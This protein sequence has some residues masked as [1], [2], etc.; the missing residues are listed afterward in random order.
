MR[1]TQSLSKRIDHLSLLF[2]NYGKTCASHQ[3]LIVVSSVVV[4]VLMFWPAITT[5]WFDT[6]S[7]AAYLWPFPTWQVTGRPSDT[8]L[9]NYSKLLRV[10]QLVL[11]V[12]EDM[13]P[14]EIMLETWQIYDALSHIRIYDEDDE[15]SL[16][17]ICY[18]TPSQQCLVLSPLAYWN[19]DPD[20]IQSDTNV[21][22]TLSSA[23]EN[24]QDEKS[25]M[26]CFPLWYVLGGISEGATKIPPRIEDVR[27]SFFLNGTYPQVDEIWND[28][29]E[30]VGE[31]NMSI[32]LPERI[33]EED[34][35]SYF[36]FTKIKLP[37]RMSFDFAVLIF[38]YGAVFSYT[39]RALGARAHLVK[40]KL[41]LGCMAVAV[42]FAAS[43][44]AISIC[45]MVGIRLIYVPWECFL[46]FTIVVGVE[47]MFILT[48]AIVATSV[49]LPVKERVGL[50]VK[51][52]G[53]PI[54]TTLIFELIVLMLGAMIGLPS[55]REF[56][57]LAS[58]ALVTDFALQMTFFLT[59]LSVDIRRLELS[60]LHDRRVAKNIQEA[61]TK[62]AEDEQTERNGGSAEMEKRRASAAEQERLIGFRNVWM[63]RMVS[64][65]VI[66]SLIIFVA[67]IHSM[68]NGEPSSSI[69]RWIQS[70]KL[71]INIPPRNREKI[72][73][74]FWQHMGLHHSDEL[75][76][77]AVP[78]P[79][80]VSLHD[81]GIESREIELA[82]TSYAWLARVW[83]IYGPVMIAG[84]VVTFVLYRIFLMRNKTKP[85]KQNGKAGEPRKRSNKWF[86]WP[87]SGTLEPDTFHPSVRVITLKG[88]HFA[89]VECL[90]ASSDAAAIV[91]C[92]LD[93]QIVAWDSL[94]GKWMRRL[95]RMVEMGCPRGCGRANW[96]GCANE[97]VSRISKQISPSSSLSL[98]SASSLL[99]QHRQLDRSSVRCAKVDRYGK[100]FAAGFDDGVIRIWGLRTGVLFRE[101]NTSVLEGAD[102][103][104]RV[105]FM[106]FAS[107]WKSATSSSGRTLWPMNHLICADRAGWI[108]EW[109]LNT[110]ECVYEERREGGVNAL[111]V[112]EQ[113]SSLR[114][115]SWVLIG[116]KEGTLTCWERTYSSDEPFSENKSAWKE[117]YSIPSIS[118]V[119][120]TC[121][122]GIAPTSNCGEAFGGLGMTLGLVVI[123]TMDGSVRAMHL[124]SGETLSVLS[125]GGV[126]KPK[127]ADLFPAF[128]GHSTTVSGKTPESEANREAGSAES[129]KGDVKDENPIED[130]RGH[131]GA[132][133]EIVITR[134]TP[135]HSK[136]KYPSRQ[137]T[138]G[139]DESGG[140]HWLVASSSMDETVRI[141]RIQSTEDD[142]RAGNRDFQRRQYQRRRKASAAA[143]NFPSEIGMSTAVSASIASTT[144]SSVTDPPP[145]STPPASPASSSIANKNG[146]CT[147]PQ[148]LKLDVVFLGVVEQHGARSIALCQN[149]SML[150]GARRTKQ[151]V[152]QKGV[153][154]FEWEF[155]MVDFRL[156]DIHV[157]VIPITGS[158]DKLYHSR[159]GIQRGPKVLWRWRSIWPFPSRERHQAKKGSRYTN[160]SIRAHKR[161]RTITPPLPSPT[162]TPTTMAPFSLLSIPTS[163]WISTEDLDAK[164]MLPFSFVRRVVSVGHNGIAFDFGNFVKVVWIGQLGEGERLGRKV[165]GSAEV[166][167]RYCFV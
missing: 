9:D 104:R 63:A 150:C 8:H 135:Y 39:S 54:S 35:I 115:R 59:V 71:L 17:S 64:L 55:V 126:R 12:H 160:A 6:T 92:G 46:I 159:A 87:T 156:P 79:V 98:N 75:R 27:M 107:S 19:Y 68:S 139:N 22:E 40:S 43:I 73:T 84:F 114:L 148:R 33:L 56:C 14:K 162:S 91:S 96:I 142:E 157:H 51:N 85:S 13:T 122:S 117:L 45:S 121:L 21:M 18:R 131:R 41:G 26:S 50:G 16:E 90:E 58:A 140:S 97:V 36:W 127:C 3:A 137:N 164:H 67:I 1:F 76:I 10:E 7:G 47:N 44:I 167:C 82:L 129:G 128:Y 143:S 116:G 134:F 81:V 163:S 132:I 83:R 161:M 86:T 57:F 20:R 165:H 38:S 166:G 109:D 80:E 123:G 158:E 155:W 152:V 93:G 62:R 113:T 99:R 89:D 119:P 30:Q 141:W 28:I 49:D 144:T 15:L 145:K 48:N 124:E 23:L 102:S 88:R 106:S 53:V 4:I 110:G 105:T 2:Y 32:R 70:V 72:A 125:Q 130:R 60:D 5:Y 147:V 112:V 95:D 136:Q 77:L 42:I 120:I 78:P 118:T 69:N 52:V 65:L 154:F 101:L 153:P 103:D 37:S 94:A 25:D 34:D 138:H 24:C 100:W 151:G 149:A 66:V 31:F 133:T 29:L 61:S 11:K 146:A 108:R 111:C 74:Q